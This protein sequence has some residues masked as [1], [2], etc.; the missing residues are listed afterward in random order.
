[1]NLSVL[2]L[3]QMMRQIPLISERQAADIA[4][5]TG[6]RGN[7]SCPGRHSNTSC[8]GRHSNASCPASCQNATG[9]FSTLVMRVQV[10]LIGTHE[11]ARLAEIIVER[12]NRR[13]GCPSHNSALHRRLLDVAL[14]SLTNDMLLEFLE[15]D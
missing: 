7:T 15:T 2:T 6:H 10:L 3:C 8:L 9:V 1:M 13:Y 4:M 14:V 11:I 12:R 5:I